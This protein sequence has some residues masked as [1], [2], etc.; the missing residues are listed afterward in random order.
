[1]FQA[2]RIRDFRLLWG[3]SLISS[4]GTWLL[5]LAV[6][7]HVLI[8]T[9]SLRDSGMTLAAQYAPALILGP[10]AGVWAD[11][12]DRRRLMIGTDLLCAGA[13]AALLLGLA[14]GR[15]WVLYVALAAESGGSVLFA[16]AMQARTPAIVG[17]GRLLT[18]ANS[19][20]A[21]SDGVVRLI[22]G[23]LGG[24]LLAVAGIRWLIVVDALS[25]LASATAIAFTTRTPDADQPRHRPRP[26]QVG[27]RL[28]HRLRGGARRFR[29]RTGRSVVADLAGGIRALRD[30]RTATALLPVTVTFLA[31]NASL[32]AVLIAF[33]VRRLGGTGHTGFL[34]SC[35]GVGFLLGAPIT[36]V[37]LDRVQPRT[38]LAATLT[39]TAAG[40]FVLF[41]ASGL[42]VALPAAVVIGMCGS[43]STMI[44][45]TVVQRVVPDAALGRVCAVFLTCEAAATL[46]GSVAGPFLA[47]AAQFTRVATVA[48]ACT[49]GAAV[50]TLLAVPVMPRQRPRFRRASGSVN[51]GAGTCACS[52]CRTRA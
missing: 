52:R 19:L 50:L 17:T 51:A 32:S 35:L 21:A 48:S 3:A 6:P 39:A 36:R 12:W 25:Y 22:G 5:I 42:E 43:M 27:L 2:L 33:G 29:Q 30:Q 37:L 14:P 16:P 47:Q 13:V 15:L 41:T 9:G 11:R 18:S 7:A 38:I 4:L 31:A 40:Y 49:L 23:P 10:L 46:M 45:L 8:A 1:M 28:G 26:A 44:P 24:I 20:F 34:L